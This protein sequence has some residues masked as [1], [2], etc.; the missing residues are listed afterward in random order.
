VSG[1]NLQ[2]NTVLPVAGVPQLAPIDVELIWGNTDT[3]SNGMYAQP[4]DTAI[5]INGVRDI[6]VPFRAWSVTDS[7]KVE[8]LVMDQDI[9]A[10]KRWDPGERIIFLTP[11]RYRQSPSD[12]HVQLDI[13]LPAG[14]IQMPG[15]GDINYIFTIKPI[16]S[17]DKYYF[18]TDLQ[19]LTNLKTKNQFVPDKFSL[20]QNYPNPFN[21]YTTI[22]YT[23]PTSGKVNL[24]LYNILGQQIKNLVNK[25]LEAGS[26]KSLFNAN[27]F[28]SGIYFYSFSFENHTITKKMIL[29]K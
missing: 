8:L 20:E 23:I 14:Q 7:E 4:S 18:E 21:A 15:P 25:N 22:K 17:N 28:A 5:G 27:N 29:L 16:T 9:V 13:T 1:T 2:F 6:I 3:L 24:S 26:Y 11:V 12:T 19:Y 10:N